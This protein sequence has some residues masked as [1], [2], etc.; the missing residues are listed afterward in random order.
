MKPRNLYR[1]II[2][3]LMIISGI[4]SMILTAGEAIIGTILL[5]AGLAFLITGITR[6]RQYGNE[7]ESDER[8]KK[9]GAY[10]LSYAWLTGLLFMFC[11]FWLDYLGLLRLGTQVALALSI[12]VLALSARLYQIYLFRKGDVE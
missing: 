9:I 5:V 8:S 11:L 7:P 10:G 6:H 4:A 2:G 3:I 12:V 1:I